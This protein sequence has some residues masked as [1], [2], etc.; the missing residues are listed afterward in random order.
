MLSFSSVFVMKQNW[1]YIV[2]VR[3]RTILQVER[4]NSTFG[5]TEI[6]KLLGKKYVFYSLLLMVSGVTTVTLTLDLEGTT[7]S[8]EHVLF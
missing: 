3:K 7:N 8:S 1:N 4:E 2:R 5:T 6:H